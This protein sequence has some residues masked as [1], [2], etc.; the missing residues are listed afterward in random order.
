[1]TRIAE[2]IFCMRGSWPSLPA[3]SWRFTESLATQYNDNDNYSVGER[4]IDT[5]TERKKE[6]ERPVPRVVLVPYFVHNF[7]RNSP[8]WR[9][10]VGGRVTHPHPST[11]HNSP[12][13]RVVHKVVALEFFLYQ[14]LSLQLAF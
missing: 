9:V 4:E 14:Q 1:M 10:V 2:E 8:T 7:V 11:N 6:R 13:G 12:R 5:H 3:I